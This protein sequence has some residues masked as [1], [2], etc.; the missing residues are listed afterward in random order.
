MSTNKIVKSTS[1][2]GLFTLFSRVLGFIRDIVIAKLFGTSLAA[3]AFFVSFRI[4]NMLRN[5]VGE[6]S[7]N[8]AVVPVVSDYTEEEKHQDFLSV[9]NSVM[10]I[11]LVFLS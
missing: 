10:F 9:S 8:A 4:P 7:V 5:L 6:G 2:I 11:A 1:V 3:E